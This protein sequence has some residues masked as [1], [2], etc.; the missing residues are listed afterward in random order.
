MPEW[1]RRLGVSADS[2]YEAARLGQILGCSVSDI[3]AGQLDHLHPTGWRRS[4]EELFTSVDTAQ[5]P[6]APAG[7][8]AASKLPR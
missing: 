7:R 5:V 8:P 6:T 3:S 2:A 4:R 1:A